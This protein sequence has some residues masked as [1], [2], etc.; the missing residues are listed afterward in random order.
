MPLAVSCGQGLQLTNILKDI[1]EDWRGG[2][3][4]MPREVFLAEGV[5]LER[6]P[7]ERAK[8]G[9]AI[10]LAQLVGIA[11][12]HLEDALEYIKLLPAGETGIRRYCLWAVGMAV[13]SLRRIH[14]NPRF[15]GETEVRI[16]RSQVR[17]IIASTSAFAPCNPALSLLFT[18]L[19]RGL[20]AKPG[21]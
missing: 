2:A 1:W 7:D 11:R 15:S 9:F 18:W 3:C 19:N 20:P 8:P 5:A 16:S 21:R 14:A 4:W 17:G 6:L 12:G 13:L 10:A